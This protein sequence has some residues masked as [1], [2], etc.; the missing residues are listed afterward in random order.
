VAIPI[1][2]PECHKKYQAPDHMAGK[3]VKCKYCGVVFLIAADA[4]SADEGQDLSALDELN[5]LHETGKHAAKR[6]PAGAGAG[7]ED[8][9]SLFHCEY[10]SEGAPRTNKLYIFPMSRLLDHWLPPVLLTIGL[11]WMVREAFQRNDTGQGWVGFF[12][13]ALFLIAFF[14]SVFPFT[15]MGLRAASCKLNYELPPKPGLRAMGI[16]AVPFAFACAMWLILGGTSG[17]LIGLLIGAI[18]A[19]PL[20]FLLFRLMPH[21]APV[22][23]AYGTGSF[24]LSVAVVIAAAFALNLMLVGTLRATKTEQALRVSPFGPEFQWDGPVEKVKKKLAHVVPQDDTPTTEESPSTAPTTTPTTPPATGPTT[25]LASAATTG[26]SVPT[27]RDVVRPAGNG[28][29]VAT[30]TPPGQGAGAGNPKRPGKAGLV[31][32]VKVV[33][34]AGIKYVV[35]P[36][37]PGTRAAAVRDGRPGHDKVELWDTQAG[38]QVSAMEV[39]RSP[40]GNS[41]ALG[42]DGEFLCFVTDFPRLAIQV[43]SP[44][45]QKF[46]RQIDLDP[47]DEKP[48]LV[49]FCSTDQVVILRVRNGQSTLQLWNVKTAA[50]GRPFVVTDFNPDPNRF[51]I[52]PDGG[53]IAM[54]LQGNSSADLESYSLATGRPVKQ[55]PIVEVNVANNVV[56]TGLAFTPDGQ[57]IAAVF[58]DGQGAGF[59]VAWP[60]AG[61]GGKALLQH[62]LPVGVNLPPPVAGLGWPSFE[63]RALHWLD[64]GRAWLIHAGSIFDTESG[65]MLGSLGLQGVKSVDTSPDGDTCFVVKNDDFDGQHLAAVQ[66]N[67]A[68]ARAGLAPTKEASTPSRGC[69]P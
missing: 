69:A 44:T 46:L 52:S 16:Y 51:A 19:L 33:I 68:A 36:S 26:P 11:V 43:W 42:P 49:G 20:L 18:V 23:F 25:R 4:R 58:A 67:L 7:G 57:R 35:F 17:L 34:P 30:T 53:T 45:A 40:E 56:I 31:A 12:R 28:S 9:D 13:A 22:T 8:I 38:K 65:A 61:R 62:F 24:L 59:F 2:C 32:D 21:E 29:S 10:P 50:H 55:M 41:Y 5:A 37:L 1:Q 63:G 48:R 54:I 60:A 15:R 3:R 66:L 39:P 14:A 6:G 27:E 47:G 64:K